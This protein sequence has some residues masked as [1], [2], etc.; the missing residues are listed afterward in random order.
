MSELRGGDPLESKNNVTYYPS[1]YLVCVDDTDPVPSNERKK[2]R[3][4]RAFTYSV[5]M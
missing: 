4:L 5:Y 1:K 3:R 2:I